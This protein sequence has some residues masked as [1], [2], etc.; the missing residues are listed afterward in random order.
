MSI[1]I[2]SS[3]EDRKLVLDALKEISN[4]YTRTEAE[5]DFVKE[6]INE[7]ADKVEI[8]KKHIRQLAKIYHKQ[9]LTEVRD[10]VDTIEAL[11]EAIVK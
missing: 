8:E 10:Q 3:P 9:N 11:Y 2:P 6:T 7:L 4:S 1:I 5:K